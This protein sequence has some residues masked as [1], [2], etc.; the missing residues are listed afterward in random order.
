MNICEICCAKESTTVTQDTGGDVFICDECLNK[1][2]EAKPCVF[3]HTQAISPDH[4]GFFKI[5][6]LEYIMKNNLSFIQGNIIKYITRAKLK[7]GLKDLE[8]A[9]TYLD[10]LIQE[11]KDGKA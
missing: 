2:A 9:K 7:D 3:G 11:V 6:P 1:T 5:Q 10:L 8:K 4:Y